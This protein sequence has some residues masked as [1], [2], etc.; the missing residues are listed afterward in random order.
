VP[1]K[2]MF[3][4]RRRAQM[5]SADI[6]EHDLYLT[7]FARRTRGKQRCAPD[8]IRLRVPQRDRWRKEEATQQSDLPTSVMLL[9][10]AHQR[11]ILRTRNRKPLT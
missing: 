5:R 3:P 8:K 2:G 4:P 7:P 6:A 1:R 9:L 10:G 11:G